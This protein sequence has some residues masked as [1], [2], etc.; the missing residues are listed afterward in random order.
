VKKWQVKS[1]DLLKIKDPLAPGG[2]RVR[3][4]SE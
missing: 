3:E 4:R 1:D 2:K